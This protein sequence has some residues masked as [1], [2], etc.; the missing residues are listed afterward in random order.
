[1]NRC[2]WWLK[3]SPNNSIPLS[4]TSTA[5]GSSSAVRWHKAGRR[6]LSR[7]VEAKLLRLWW[8]IE[9][10]VETAALGLLEEEVASRKD[11]SLWGGGGNGSK[12]QSTVFINTR[13]SFRHLNIG[14]QICLYLNWIE[15]YSQHLVRVFA[16]DSEILHANQANYLTCYTSNQP[17]SGRCGRVL[18][19]TPASKFGMSNERFAINTRDYAILHR[20]YIMSTVKY[21]HLE[22]IQ[23]VFQLFLIYGLIVTD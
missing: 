22:C 16:R 13:L 21:D 8:G 17:S 14:F 9:G 10:S 11:F 15:T 4:S 20:V 3:H 5:L 19:S 18:R 6:S 7:S 2:Q 12:L 23:N 1:M